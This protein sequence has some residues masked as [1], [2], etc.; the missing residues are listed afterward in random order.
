MMNQDSGFAKSLKQCEKCG[1]KFAEDR[2]KRYEQML[3]NN[4]ADESV[5]GQLQFYMAYHRVLTEEGD[6]RDLGMMDAV[7]DLL[8]LKGLVKSRDCFYK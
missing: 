7:N 3:A 5:L 4:K 8:R 1:R 6:K 2:I